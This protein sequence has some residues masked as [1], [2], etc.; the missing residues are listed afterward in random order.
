VVS[1][2]YGDFSLVFSSFNCIRFILDSISKIIKAAFARFII[3]ATKA[4]QLLPNGQMGNKR[5][6]LTDLAIRMMV[7]IITKARRS[8]GITFLL[9]LNIKEAFNAIHH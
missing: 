4:K 9:Q 5:D 1:Q 3:N 6:K 7:K 8:G 2:S